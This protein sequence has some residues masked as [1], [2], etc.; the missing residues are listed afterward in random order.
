MGSVEI[1]VEHITRLVYGRNTHKGGLTK[2]LRQGPFTQA[3]F[4]AIFVC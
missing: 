3:I 2:A 4:A 1:Q